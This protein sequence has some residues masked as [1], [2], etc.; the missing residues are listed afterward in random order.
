MYDV[1]RIGKLRKQLDLTQKDLAKLAGVS[2]S[3]IAKIESNR[4]DP[5]YSKVV[6]IITALEMQLN[7]SKK[8]VSQI[9]TKDIISIKPTDSI[10]HAIDLM[11]SKDISQLPVFDGNVCVGSISDR[12]VIDLMSKDHNSLKLTKINQIMQDVYPSVPISAYVDAVSDLMKHYRAVLVEKNGT[13]VGIVTKAD[14]LK[15]I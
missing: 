1:Q 8:T 12:T 9:M 7:K 14:L 2:Q 3:L 15:V 13:I 5:A 10:L 11:R 4:I 6:Q